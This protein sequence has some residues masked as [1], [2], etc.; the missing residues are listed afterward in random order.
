M[1]ET[2]RAL[3]ELIGAA[4]SALDQAK[5]TGWNKICISAEPASDGR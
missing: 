5:G 1:N 2:R 4:D 3:T